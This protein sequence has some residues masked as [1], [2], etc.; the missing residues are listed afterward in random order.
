MKNF[1]L[2]LLKKDKSINIDAYKTMYEYFQKQLEHEKSRFKNLEDKSSKIFTML[3]IIITAYTYI[4]TTLININSIEKYNQKLVFLIILIVLM[5]FLFFFL[6]RAWLNLFNSFKLENTKHLG[7][8]QKAI[9]MFINNSENLHEVYHYVADQSAEIILA[10][11]NSNKIKA[12]LIIQACKNISIS[13]ILFVILLGLSVIYR[14][15]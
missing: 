9:D 3:S 6:S 10:Y 13:A 2:N 12:E 1:I 15:I 14:A 5:V 7:A 8:D 11:K 4:I